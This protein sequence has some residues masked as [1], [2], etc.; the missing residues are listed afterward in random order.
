[1]QFRRH[2]FPRSWNYGFLQEDS[3]QMS[4]EQEVPER[5]SLEEDTPGLD[6][7]PESAEDAARVFEQD[8]ATSP[9]EGG[10]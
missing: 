7:A 3:I 4:E 9:G 2:C 6:P 1:M 10:G 8:D 5:G